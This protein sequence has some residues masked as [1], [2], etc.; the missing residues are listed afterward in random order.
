MCYY[1]NDTSL[2]LLKSPAHNEEGKTLLYVAL[3]YFKNPK[4]VKGIFQFL[5]KEYLLVKNA[6]DMAAFSGI[7]E[8]FLL[9][10]NIPTLAKPEDSDQSNTTTTTTKKSTPISVPIDVFHKF[11]R[12]LSDV[13]KDLNEF[14][15]MMIESIEKK[16][17]L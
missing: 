17:K 6:D 10:E 15:L 14:G 16:M 3:R 8:K 12:D 2:K 5:S 4:F 11:M 1:P 9:H 7:I 13:H